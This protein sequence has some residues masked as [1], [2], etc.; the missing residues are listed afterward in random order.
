MTSELSEL[1]L[2]Y[3][4]VLDH[5]AIG[6]PPVPPELKAA[7]RKAFKGSFILA[8]GFDAESAESA[9]K[10]GRADMIAFGRP[11]L[12]NPDLVMRMQ[13]GAALNPVDMSTF[14]TPGA[15]GYTDYPTLS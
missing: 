2:V 13:K 14:Y 3:L 6:A 15:K 5:S 8:G 12:A 11:F 9:L 7:L 4:H 1:G 10:E